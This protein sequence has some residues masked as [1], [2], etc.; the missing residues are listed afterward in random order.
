[1]TDPPRDT[2]STSPEQMSYEQLVEAL[3][4]LTERMSDGDIGI[5]EAV[6]L[7]ERAGRLEELA[8]A[9]LEKVQQRIRA[10]ADK[11]DGGGAEEGDNP[12]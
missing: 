7:Y 6:D 8:R 1:M 5:E 10:L 9:R 11:G 12:R 3:E 4:H 2:P